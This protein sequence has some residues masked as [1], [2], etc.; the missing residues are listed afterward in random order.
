MQEIPSLGL[1]SVPAQF[2]EA[3]TG[4]NVCGDPKIVLEEIR[5]SDDFTQDR[6]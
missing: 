5:R 6:T 1:H 3:W 2:I 4:P